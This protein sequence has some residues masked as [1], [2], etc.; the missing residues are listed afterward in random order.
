MTELALKTHSSSGTDGDTWIHGS[1]GVDETRTHTHIYIHH[2]HIHTHTHTDRHTIS[3]M[4]TT[5][6]HTS[7]RIDD[8]NDT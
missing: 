2:T 6:A 5:P 3:A 1:G 8:D 4:T 7:N